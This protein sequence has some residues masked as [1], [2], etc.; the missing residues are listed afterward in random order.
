[1]R[2]G[3]VVLLIRALYLRFLFIS[4]K[5][6]ENSVSTGAQAF[7]SKLVHLTANQI[8]FQGVEDTKNGEIRRKIALLLWLHCRYLL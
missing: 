5:F 7:Y 3:L 1:M 4:S 6:K 2:Q 8:G